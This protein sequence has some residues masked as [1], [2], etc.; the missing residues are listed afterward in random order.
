MTK[1]RQY[2]SNTNRNIPTV[3]KTEAQTFISAHPIPP[4][5]VESRSQIG[6]IVQIELTIKLDKK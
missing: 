4:L 2:I 1:G 6:N 3:E 5:P